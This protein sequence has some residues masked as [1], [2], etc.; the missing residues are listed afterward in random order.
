MRTSSVFV[1][2]CLAVGIAPLFAHPPGDWIPGSSIHLLPLNEQ[3]QG[4]SM[5]FLL[6]SHET[7]LQRALNA[8]PS[9]PSRDHVAVMNKYLIDT[10]PLRDSLKQWNKVYQTPEGDHSLRKTDHLRSDI[11]YSSHKTMMVLNRLVGIHRSSAVESRFS[12]RT[13]TD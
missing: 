12:T 9:T 1:I 3:R 11:I 13:R 2:F 7:A 5:I 8:L 10:G 6:T 4:L